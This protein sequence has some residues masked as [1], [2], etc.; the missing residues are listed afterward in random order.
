MHQT[1]VGMRTGAAGNTE[2]TLLRELLSEWYLNRLQVERGRCHDSGLRSEMP[3]VQGTAICRKQGLQPARTRR[4]IGREAGRRL[5]QP[6]PCPGT[7]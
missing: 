1:M 2:A 3:R 7:E 6:E 4:L 5:G